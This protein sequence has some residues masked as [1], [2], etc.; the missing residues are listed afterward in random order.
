M[1]TNNLFPKPNL[2]EVT[3]LH[4]PLN[5]SKK[6]R[7]GYIITQTT[8][9]VYTL[10]LFSSCSRTEQFKKDCDLCKQISEKEVKTT[11]INFVYNNITAN[12][13]KE[14]EI[15]LT[16]EKTTLQHGHKFIECGCIENIVIYHLWCSNNETYQLEV[17]LL[18]N[19]KFTIVGI[20]EAEFSHP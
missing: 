8:A 2:V 10:L 3:L 14:A 16:K 19:K 11:M 4:K 13:S 7:R 18:D 5:Q 17:K 20:K 12:I 15:Q 9:L 6:P 1:E